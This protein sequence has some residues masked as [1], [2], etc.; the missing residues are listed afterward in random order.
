MTT[1][2]P[3]SLEMI[4]VRSFTVPIEMSESITVRGADPVMVSAT[5]SALSGDSTVMGFVNES[6]PECPVTESV[7]S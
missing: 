7:I 2:F 4:Q 5:K 6:L 1:R 3:G